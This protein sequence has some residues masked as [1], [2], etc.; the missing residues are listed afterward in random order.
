MYIPES[1][2][3]NKF[4]VVNIPSA[5]EIFMRFGFCSGSSYTGDDKALP[6]MHKVDMAM[7]FDMLNQ[8]KIDEESIKVDPTK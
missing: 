3:L 5:K 1:L 2:K 4:T 7:H 6:P 8:S